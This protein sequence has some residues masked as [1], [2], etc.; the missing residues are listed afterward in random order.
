M[1][2][3]VFDPTLDTLDALGRDLYADWRKH[4]P[5]VYRY[6]RRRS[7]VPQWD[8]L[9]SGDRE[10]WCYLAR[11]LNQVSARNQAEAIAAY[12]ALIERQAAELVR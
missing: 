12:V 8:A 10:A 3:P 6:Q 1:P 4:H 11:E 2:T 9:S 5:L 7:V